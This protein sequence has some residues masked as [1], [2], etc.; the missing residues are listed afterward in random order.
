[1]QYNN[2]KDNTIYVDVPIANSINNIIVIH[3]LPCDNSAA[4]NEIELTTNITIDDN[5]EAYDNI[6]QSMCLSK[7]DDAN[8]NINVFVF[9]LIIVLV[10]IIIIGVLVFYI[11]N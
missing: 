3:P 4:L 2:F 1:M 7:H 5:I 8:I 9:K 10:I 6:T 11:K